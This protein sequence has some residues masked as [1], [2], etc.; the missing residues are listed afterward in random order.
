MN[1]SP[2]V[3]VMIHAA[4]CVKDTAIPNIGECIDDRPCKNDHSGT[5]YSTGTDKCPWMHQRH[6]SKT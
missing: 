6:S 5:K 2:Q 3:T 4:E 1:T